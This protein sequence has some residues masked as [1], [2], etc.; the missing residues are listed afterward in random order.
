[1]NYTKVCIRTL[2]LNPAIAPKSIDGNTVRMYIA[3]NIVNIHMALD[4]VLSS[5]WPQFASMGNDCYVVQNCG[6]ISYFTHHH[7]I[8]CIGPF[9]TQ[10]HKLILAHL[11]CCHFGR[12]N[13]LSLLIK[14]F[15][16]SPQFTVPH[17]HH[18]AHTTSG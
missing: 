10:S 17:Q 16:A 15:N 9:A 18:I 2:S 7:T 11:L 8:K 12:P 5:G 14:D 13:H 1:M 4:Y 3:H 6:I